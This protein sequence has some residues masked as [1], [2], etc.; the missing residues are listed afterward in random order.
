M[1]INSNITGVLFLASGLC[2]ATPS[3]FEAC[4]RPELNSLDVY[5][6][7]TRETKRADRALNE[8]YIVLT[9]LIA[10]EYHSDIKAGNE[11]LNKIRDSQRAWIK[12]RDKN[13]LIETFVI[14][15][16]TLAF[17]TTRN[18]CIT[19]ET[20]LRTRYLNELRF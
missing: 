18:S 9:D 13:C 7:S 2:Y 3:S 14:T 12:L 16:G 1:E 17:E 19:K 15:P 8:S 20:T 11:L 6:C 5:E 10:A 4:S